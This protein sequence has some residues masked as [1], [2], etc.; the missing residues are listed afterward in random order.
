MNAKWLV[1]VFVYSTLFPI[2][3]E[4]VLCLG[5]GGHWAIEQAGSHCCAGTP[6]RA[7][8]ETA[9]LELGSGGS[10]GCGGCT[11]TQ[12]VPAALAPQ[13][14]SAPGVLASSIADVYPAGERESRALRLPLWSRPPVAHGSA[15]LLFPRTIS[16]RR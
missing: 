7:I 11:D 13:M 4:A 12:L 16:L 15:T 5:P 1:A 6:N 3:G 8:A 10:Q 14:E 9:L 2:A